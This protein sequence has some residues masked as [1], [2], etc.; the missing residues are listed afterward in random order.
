[1]AA[2]KST[3]K[4]RVSTAAKLA[5]A[6]ARAARTTKAFRQVRLSNI[7]NMIT[8]EPQQSVRYYAFKLG[9]IPARLSRMV[10]VETPLRALARQGQ[11]AVMDAGAPPFWFRKMTAKQRVRVP[12]VNANQQFE[13]MGEQSPVEIAVSD[14]VTR[15]NHEYFGHTLAAYLQR[16]GLT[17]DRIARELTS[18]VETLKVNAVA[19][20]QIKVQIAEIR[21][22]ATLAQKQESISLRIPSAARYAA[23]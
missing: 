4:V 16:T 12:V 1:M 10:H 18:Y 3:T 21:D 7:V 9:M 8:E 6:K 5:L 17:P 14:R 2:K 20:S 23:E 11:I 22:I 15:E 19:Q 13:K